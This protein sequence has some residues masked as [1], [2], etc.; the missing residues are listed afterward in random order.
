MICF[1]RN[2]FSFYVDFSKKINIMSLPVGSFANQSTM[3]K[4]N[5]AKNANET[6]GTFESPQFLQIFLFDTLALYPFQ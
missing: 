4:R 3:I 5:I 1:F 2:I 6:S